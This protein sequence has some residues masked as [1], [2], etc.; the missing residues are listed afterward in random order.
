M[1]PDE[2]IGVRKQIYNGFVVVSLGEVYALAAAG[3]ALQE[4][5][6]IIPAR[7]MAERFDER[8][9]AAERTSKWSSQFAIPQRSVTTER[10]TNEQK[11]KR[12]PTLWTRNNGFYNDQKSAY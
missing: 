10:T 3:T 2:K 6:S 4:L 11:I 8:I 7:T 12:P 5:R 9:A 1:V